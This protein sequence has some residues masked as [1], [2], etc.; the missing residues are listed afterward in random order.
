[1]DGRVSTDFKSSNKIKISWLV[2]VLLNF[3]RFQ[4]SPRRWVDWGRVGVSVWRSTPC[5]HAHECMH[6]C[7]CMLNMINMDASIKVVICNFYTCVCV[8]VHACTCMST[9]VGRPLHAPRCP[10]PTICFLPKSHREPKTEF[11]KSW[12]NWDNSILFDDS[13]PLNTL[14]LI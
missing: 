5:R 3:Y 6:A 4:G 7:T 2:Q 14:E 10:P 11:N 8:H 1:M 13:L 9:C 12:T